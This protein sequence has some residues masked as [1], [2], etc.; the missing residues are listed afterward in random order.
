MVTH[1][2]MIDRNNKGR[3]IIQQIAYFTK[4]KLIVPTTLRLLH[5]LRQGGKEFINTQLHVCLCKI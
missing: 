3:L 2:R 1:K 5:F 4:I